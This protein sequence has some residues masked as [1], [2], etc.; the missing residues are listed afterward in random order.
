GLTDII[1]AYVLPPPLQAPTAGPFAITAAVIGLLAGLWGWLGLFGPRRT[2]DT[3]SLLVAMP[4]AAMIALV[5]AYT[6]SRAY[7]SP[8]GFNSVTGFSVNAFRLSEF[9]FALVMVVFIL[10][11]AWLLVARRDAGAVLALAAGLLTGIVA[12]LVSAPIAAFVFGGVT[13]FGGDLI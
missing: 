11:A 2:T 12:A 13:G 8:K 5:I 1:W 9:A 3:T 10:L 6:F 7:T 4:A